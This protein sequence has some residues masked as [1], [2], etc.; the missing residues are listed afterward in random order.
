MY[1]EFFDK[2][3][4]IIFDLNGTIIQDEVLWGLIYKEVF[5]EEILSDYPYFG[6]QGLTLRD[7][8]ELILKGN[9]FRSKADADVYYKIIT[10]KYFER[11]DKSRLTE[12][13]NDFINKMIN[14]NKRM[15]LVSNS[16]SYITKTTLATLELT[17]FFEFV[18]TS[19]DVLNPKP[20]PEIY[21]LAVE[22]FGVKKNK[23]LVFED[24]LVGNY[25][26]EKAGLER[27]IILPENLEEID[28]GSDTEHFIENFI[29]INPYIDISPED[30][31]LE[32]FNQYK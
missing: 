25:S 28:Y 24:S 10:T 11:I 27:M 3:E 2:F 32:S 1:K 15:A 6:E 26:A 5:A 29:E 4:C 12:G 30:Y 22:K 13:F 14:L 9:E 31:I 23:I 16:D 19:D 18:L 20:S 21:E 17:H 8:I 7:N